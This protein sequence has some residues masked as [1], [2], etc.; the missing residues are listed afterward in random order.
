MMSGK[1]PSWLRKHLNQL[2]EEKKPEYVQE[3]A[4]AREKRE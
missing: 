3:E 2:S 4:V 1:P